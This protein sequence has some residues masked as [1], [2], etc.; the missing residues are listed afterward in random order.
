LIATANNRIV[1]RSYP[2][3]LSD[4]FEPPYRIHRIKELLIAKEKHSLDDVIE[5]QK[6]VVSLQAKS[7]IEEL[8]TDIEKA[9]RT[10]R[11]LK[12]PGE[13]LIHWDGKCSANSPE[14]SLSHVFHQ[15][16]MANLLGP[17]LGEELYLAYTE[18]FNQAL[19]PID[20]ILKDPQS[21]WFATRSRESLVEG[22]L[23]EAC[24]ELRGLL[25]T[26]IDQWSWGK[27]HTLIMTHSL[28]R[29]KILAPLFSL[30]PF[31]SPGDGVTI[32][33]GFY[34]HSNP[35]R[36]IVGPSLRMIVDLSDPPR[37]RFILSSG[38]SG[39]PF[40]PHYA[41]QLELWRRGDYIQLSD[42]PA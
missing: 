10:D 22:S 19:A 4:L 23:R 29:S 33:L 20:E 34:R 14:A 36:H 39:H 32:N 17:E 12:G 18:I 35:Y 5:M 13:R 11:T 30:G 37:S 3:H 15:R 38:Q 1:D 8:R 28:G 25:G 26:D 42:L 27:L 40:S 31:P 21:A 2:Y 41:D 6:D 24:H 9:T 7:M 16:L